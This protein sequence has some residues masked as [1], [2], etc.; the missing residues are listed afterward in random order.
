MELIALELEQARARAFVGR[1]AEL[2][3]LEGLLRRDGSARLAWIY[4]PG[5][6]GKTELLGELA[7]RGQRAGLGVARLDGATLSPS[8]E[9][10]AGEIQAAING[11]A[12]LVL[13]DRFEHVG[14]LEP[15]LR[16]IL[17]PQ[18]PNTLRIVIA[19]REP[20]DAA[21]RSSSLRGIALPLPLEA[22]DPPSLSAWL[23]RLQ[24]PAE[25]WEQ[26]T[27]VTRGHPLAVSLFAEVAL[28]DPHAALKLSE[29][30]GIVEALLKT[31]LDA[32]QEPWQRDT[33]YAAAVVRR[34]SEELLAVLL[35]R[36]AQEAFEWLLGLSFVR[37]EPRG[38]VLHD[39]VHDLLEAELEWRHPVLRQQLRARAAQYYRGQFRSDVR[40]PPEVITDFAYLWREAVPIAA[41]TTAGLSASG[42]RPTDLPELEALV[43]RH[44]GPQSWQIFQRW[45]ERGASL[46]IVRDR[47][48]RVQATALYLW[49]ER[50][51]DT[52]FDPGATSAL[53][54]AKESG[55]QT[56]L[57]FRR[58]FLDRD[59]YQS[60]APSALVLLGWEFNN[61]VCHP[62]VRDGLTAW[63]DPA[64]GLVELPPGMLERCPSADFEVGGRSFAVIRTLARGRDQFTWCVDGVFMPLLAREAPSA[65]PSA[66][67]SLSA[68]QREVAALVGL[69][70]SNKEI[71]EQLGTSVN[72]VRNQLVVIFERLGVSSRAELAAMVARGSGR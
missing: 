70:R 6:I 56:G 4:G 34:L 23:A 28:R 3:V 13:F 58:F 18:L 38:L 29:Q 27:A 22:L 43:T 35:E 33:L 9:E 17:W 12:Q 65:G 46:V 16:E 2:E 20:P 11:G 40:V 30:P 42:L 37:L 14:S 61:L 10:I 7:R 49:L 68:R 44:E 19:S 67:E 50:L 26:I 48:G 32:V 39:L 53:H 71:A 36:A 15:W 54:Y 8:E 41:A 21:W 69:G 51:G 66:L 47:Q 72:T 24:V 57:V 52:S 1:G 60:P 25:R 31:L 5:G 64:Q 59:T 63:S 55:E 45:L 62:A